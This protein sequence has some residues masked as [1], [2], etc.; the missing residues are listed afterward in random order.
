[1]E[2]N[3]DIFYA[4]FGVRAEELKTKT[5]EFRS[6]LEDFF[7]VKHVEFEQPEAFGKYKAFFPDDAVKHPAKAYTDVLEWL[8]KRYTKPGDVVLDPMCGTGSTCIV[9]ALHG[10]HGIGVDIEERFI[11]WCNEAKRR[12]EGTTTLTPR[13]RVHFICGDAR[14]LSQLLKEHVDALITSPPY[15]DSKRGGVADADKMADRWERHRSDAWNTWGSSAHTPGRLRAFE[16]LGSG[17]SDNP[18]N[19]GNL[20][21][22]DVD[23]IITSPPYELSQSSKLDWAPSRRDELMKEK[24]I[25]RGYSDNPNNIG[26]LS[27]GDVDAIIMSPPYLKSA[28]QGGGINRQRPQDVR[29]G[30]STIGRTVENPN[31]IDNVKSYGDIDA[32]ITSPPYSGTISK[33]AGGPT[34]QLKVR[35]GESTLTARAYSESEDN[36]GNLPHGDIDAIITSPPYSES[37]RGGDVDVVDRLRRHGRSDPKAGGPYGVSLARPYSKSPEN[38]GNLPHG[39]VDAIITSPPYEESMG[40]KHSSP[41]ADELMEEKRHVTIYGASRDN[42][43]NL[44]GET[45]LEAML[46]VYSECYKALKPGGKIAIIIKPF[47]RNKQVVDLPWHTHLL[48]TKVGFKPHEFFK[49][50][51]KH[52]SFWRVLYYKKHPEVPR[53]AHEYI[54][55]YEKRF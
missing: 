47:I 34:G 15:A 30:C 11:E 55:V 2:D 6:K 12:L 3:V 28:D 14:R 20:P 25:Y 13:G 8:I 31:A 26:N 36:I 18:D 35:V 51:L 37:I 41:R 21:Y 9:A 53:I 33:H 50:R 46:K 10:R 22:G 7:E 16:S 45:Y 44:K 38:I 27:Y 24:R 43:G 52:Q 17:Y 54:L 39:D 29:I 42:I 5:N 32:I 1:M 19:I 48:M 40:S 23:A 4:L 49:Y